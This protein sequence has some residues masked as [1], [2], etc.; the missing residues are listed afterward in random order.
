MGIV[1]CGRSSGQRGAGVT[2]E[3]TTER[4]ARDESGGRVGG[5]VVHLVHHRIGERGREVSG[6]YGHRG[7]A[8]VQSGG[9]LVIARQA[10][11]A[12]R[13]IGQRDRIDVFARSGHMRVV[14]GGTCVA[15]GFAAHTGGDGH[16]ARQVVSAV[17]DLAGAQ[18]HGLGR[19]AEGI[20]VGCE[21]D[22]VIASL[23]TRT[24]QNVVV[25]HIVAS[26]AAD[27]ARHIGQRVADGG[28]AQ[29]TACQRDRQGGVGAAINLGHC[30]GRERDGPRIDGEVG[31]RPVDAVVGVIQR[32]LADEVAA[33]HILTRGAAQASAQCVATDK[34]AAAGTRVA[35][36]GVG[37][38]RIGIAINLVLPS[39][40]AHGNW[41]WCDRQRAVHC[42][43]L[44][45]GRTQ[46]AGAGRYRIAADTAVGDGGGGGLGRARQSGAGGVLAVD[47]A[48]DVLG[49]AG[50]GIAI[51]PA[52]VHSRYQERSPRDAGRHRLV[53]HAQ[54]IVAR[55]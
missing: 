23:G 5:A 22:G 8:G 54:H 12:V 21:G 17:I 16:L 29:A 1:V 9:Q 24:Q 26:R 33:A 14:G 40:G 27:R 15:Q 44:V 39:I 51:H 35:G 38:H 41:P 53:A 11:G 28:A 43:K 52:L 13:G 18:A 36:H 10:A 34:A 6:H 2:V 32:T 50:V 48:G 37:Q 42:H 19:D 47:V 7:G 4:P 55:Q 30:I 45:I 46:R 49:E 31:P 3:Q 25:A 20:V